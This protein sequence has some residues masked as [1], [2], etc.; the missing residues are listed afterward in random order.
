[1]PQFTT[2]LVD[3]GKKAFLT[4]VCVQCHGQ[5]GRGQMATNVGVDAWGNPT[6]AADLT[7][8]MLHGGTEPL[9]IY[10]HIDAGINGTPMP[11]SHANLQ[12]EPET[13]WKLVAYVLKVADERRQGI[14]P[15]SGLLQ[16]GILKPLPGV[17]PAG[18]T[19]VADRETHSE[20]DGGAVRQMTRR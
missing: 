20:P 12:K 1:M 3:Q 17:K 6:K 10:R 2:A 18:A 14:V 4:L 13:I 7:S 16:D 11:S 8:G 15:D 5:D 9:D 19:K